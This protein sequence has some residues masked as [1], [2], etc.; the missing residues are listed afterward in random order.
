MDQLSASHIS[1]KYRVTCLFSGLPGHARETSGKIRSDSITLDDFVTQP[2]QKLLYDHNIKGR[3]IARWKTI[4][5]Q[6][7]RD[8]HTSHHEATQQCI[9]YVRNH[10]KYLPSHLTSDLHLLGRLRDIFEHKCWCSKL[11]EQDVKTMSSEM[12]AN[13]LMTAASRVESRHKHNAETRAPKPGS[14]T[15][16]VGEPTPPPPI[17]TTVAASFAKTPPPSRYPNPRRYQ[18]PYSMPFGSEYHLMPPHMLRKKKNRCFGCKKPGHFLRDCPEKSKHLYRMQKLTE[19]SVGATMIVENADSEPTDDIVYVVAFVEPFE[20]IDDI[21][22]DPDF[23]AWICDFLDVLDT[24]NTPPAY[25]PATFHSFQDSFA[26]KASLPDYEKSIQN[27]SNSV[28]NCYSI[29]QYLR[30]DPGDPKK[31]CSET[32]LKQANWQPV[33]K[34]PLP[35]DIN[36]FHFAG[37]PIRAIYAVCLVSDITDIHGQTHILHPVVFVLSDTPI[38]ILLGLK[39]QP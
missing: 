1:E 31:L 3:K 36:P 19:I 25:F 30:L 32:W 34:I 26:I 33:K 35:D 38:P 8:K 20:Y 15:K 22:T 18:S 17:P 16:N 9:D 4:S 6:E 10:Q 28:N 2:K 24:A 13:K 21:A 12:F 11:Y 37:H 27:L 14:S 29:V 23:D 39:M 7:F 5:F